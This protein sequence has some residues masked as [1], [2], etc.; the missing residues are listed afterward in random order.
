MPNIPKAA[1]QAALQPNMVKAL[2]T[3]NYTKALPITIQDFELSAVLP[4]I[5]YMFRFGERRG[6]GQFLK[7]F[8]WEGATPRERR[9]EATI[10][11]VASVLA[12]EDHIA[13]FDDDHTLAVLGDLLL[14]FGL[15]NVRH[16]LGQD[17]QIQRAFPTHYLTSW[18]DLPGRAAHLRGVP[19]M[20]VAILVN[21]KKGDHIEPQ[22]KGWVGPNYDTNPLLHAF[23]EGMSVAGPPADRASDLFDE[24]CKSVGLDQLLMIRLAQLLKSAPDKAYGKG[25][26]PIL[27]ER[28]IA[29][30]AARHFSEDFRRFLRSYASEIPRLALVD[31]LEAC[32]A[33]GMMTVLTSVVK[34]VFDWSE[35]GCVP[36]QNDQRPAGIF[37]DC[38]TG[39]DKSLRLLSEQSLDDLIRQVERIQPT[40]ATLRLLDYLARNDKKIRKL[41]IGVRPDATEWINLLGELLHRRH[42]QAD[43]V[44]GTVDLYCGQLADELEA[45]HPDLSASLRDEASEPN[46]VR[47]FSAVL[48]EMMGA[49]VRSQLIGA[50]D[51]VLQTNKPIGLAQKRSTTRG[52][53][54]GGTTRR[55]RDVRSMIFSDAALEYLV[56]V[57]LLASGNK[58]G[59]RRLAMRDFLETLRV[60]YGFHVDAAPEGLSVSNELLHRN[61][62]TLE[63]R[64]RDLGLLMGVNDAESMKRLRP[65]FQP[66][67]EVQHA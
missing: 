46:A 38:S 56:H 15:E 32:M 52:G 29:A 41:G 5:F 24:N 12:K 58:T 34:I 42:A 26:T 63:R 39:V 65:R 13:G 28:P 22:S 7:T 9:Q 55:K 23:G 17:K 66:R 51:S 14:C 27:N 57:H 18:I 11:R 20:L 60:R 45:D 3:G 19:E 43:F 30:L 8:A 48:A 59:V 6:S 53:G 67:W 33:V 50:V 35:T 31:M 21:Q 40:L 4:A 47:R 62:T 61:R 1:A 25:A 10:A 2:W 64:L 44:H 16:E 37:V 54:L 36:P 49:N